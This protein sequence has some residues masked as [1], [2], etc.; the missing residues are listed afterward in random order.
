MKVV[1][2]FHLKEVRWALPDD[3]RA[4]LESRFPGVPIVSV[5]DPAELR[6][7]LADA[8]I[9]AGFHFPREHF[10]AASRLRWIH[11]ASAGVEANLF[12]ELVASDVV[13]TNSTGLHAVSIPEHV[14]GQMLVL[15]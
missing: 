15:L 1:T 12:P 10:T 6:A 5:D 11:S 8:D 9:F 4:R 7:A 2:F 14:L 3:E 13:L